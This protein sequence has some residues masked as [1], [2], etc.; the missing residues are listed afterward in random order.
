MK[1]PWM[2]LRDLED[3]FALEQKGSI[4]KEK[5]LSMKKKALCFSDK[6]CIDSVSFLMRQVQL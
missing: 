4:T 6:Y 3:L 2:L 5:Y 1:T